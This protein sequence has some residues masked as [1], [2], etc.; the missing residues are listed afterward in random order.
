M[1]FLTHSFYRAILGKELFVTVYRTISWN[2]T[3][4]PVIPQTLGEQ[5]EMYLISRSLSEI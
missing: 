2:H 1:Q 5:R 4:Q 3:H